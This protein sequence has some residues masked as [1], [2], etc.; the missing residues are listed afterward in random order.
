MS[1]LGIAS[2]LFSLF[3]TSSTGNGNNASGLTGTSESAD[4]SS[5]LALR[6][7]TL[8]AQSVSLLIGSANDASS[9]ASG[10]DFL[11]GTNNASSG[12]T[13][14]LS[15]LSL[16]TTTT[17]GLSANGRNVSLFDSESAYN[18]MS[19]IN[20]CLLYTSPSPRDGLLSR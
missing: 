4:F 16:S 11:L 5:S 15:L 17:Q 13:D 18:M 6:M 7:A 19:I 8:Q 14:P 10:L 2:T 1:S 3:P 12:S 9:T 20:T